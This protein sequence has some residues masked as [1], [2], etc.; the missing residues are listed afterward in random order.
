[1]DFLVILFGLLFLIIIIVTVIKSY[2]RCPSDKILVVYGKVGGSSR[3]AKCIHGG[4]AFIIPII[5][6]YEYLDLSPI[7]IEVGLENALSRQN[8]RV[9]VLS[10]FIVGIS[11]DEGVILNA[12]ERLL[13]LSQADIRHSASD[14]IFGQLRGIIATMDNEE[15]KADREKFITNISASVEQELRKIGLK[16]IDVNIM[17]IT[18]NA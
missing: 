15:I 9:N 17:D 10:R 18:D 5:Q 12:V 11:T 16:L 13:G 3:T 7:P 2:K 4:S 1:M 14:I 8:I 6:D